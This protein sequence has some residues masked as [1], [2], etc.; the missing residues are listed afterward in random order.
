MTFS[1]TARCEHTGELGVAVATAWFAVGSVCPAVRADIGAV[2]SQALVNA[3]LRAACLDR[4]VLGLRPELALAEALKMDAS[5]EHRQLGVVD[6]AGRA[7]AHTGAA[8]PDDSGHRIDRGCVIAGNTL[9]SIEVLDAMQS[10]WNEAR[11]CDVPLAERMLMALDAGQ[12]AGG[13][14]RGRQSAALLV[15]NVDP[16]LQIDLR[17]DDHTEPLTE[18]RRLLALFRERY[19]PIHRA[20]PA[21]SRSG[22]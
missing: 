18:L 12:L 9:S 19:E 1:I 14:A 7:A 13:D 6:A 4:I 5:P 3:N 15:G 20:L 21:T 8:C 22:S 11:G 17:V 16:M 2:A 10:S